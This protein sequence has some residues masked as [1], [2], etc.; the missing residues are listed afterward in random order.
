MTLDANGSVVHWLMLMR[1][2]KCIE[3]EISPIISLSTDE[4]RQLTPLI[5]AVLTTKVYNL[6]DF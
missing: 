5:T 1:M 4:S 3:T 6:T 2:L